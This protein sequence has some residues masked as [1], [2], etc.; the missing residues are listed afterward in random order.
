MNIFYLIKIN[1]KLFDIKKLPQ[2][3][4]VFYLLS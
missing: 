3:E 2:E 1:H 4:Y